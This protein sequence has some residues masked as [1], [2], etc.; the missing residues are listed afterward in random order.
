M[1]PTL[2][3]A[4]SW[5]C[6]GS[7]TNR[8]SV[9]LFRRLF[10]HFSSAQCDDVEST[11]FELASDAATTTAAIAADET[12]RVVPLDET[13]SKLVAAVPLHGVIDD[14]APAVGLSRYDQL[15]ER[16]VARMLV[17]LDARDLLIARVLVALPRLTPSVVHA[18]ARA[19]TQPERQ[20]L[21]PACLPVCLPSPSSTTL[22]AQALATL[23]DLCLQRPADTGDALALLLRCASSVDEALRSPAVRLVAT[24]LHEVPPV[25]SSRLLSAS[26]D[27]LTKTSL[28]A[29]AGHRVVCIARADDGNRRRRGERGG[30]GDG[31]G[32]DSGDDIDDID[33]VGNGQR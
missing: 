30:G 32:G 18:V 7:T 24:R 21:V 2:P 29:G 10:V 17:A 13:L 15:L 23:R 22:C 25:R 33:I 16:I 28:A 14:A 12:S 11:S 6:A 19:C 20:T 4:T 5:R 26:T 27:V 3:F 9:S 8:W 31:D 1:R